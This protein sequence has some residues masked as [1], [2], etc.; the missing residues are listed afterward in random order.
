[1]ILTWG[2]KGM[3]SISLGKRRK[4]RRVHAKRSEYT[5]S[6]KGTGMRT[7]DL[8]GS[9]DCTEIYNPS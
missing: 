3:I 4:T 7:G 9:P 8:D 5:E 6:Q 1:M 2:Q